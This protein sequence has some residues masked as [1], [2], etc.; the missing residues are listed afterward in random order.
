MC[1]KFRY[2]YIENC[3]NISSQT[4]LFTGAYA[5]LDEIKERLADLMPTH[6]SLTIEYY[7]KKFGM[8]NRRQIDELPSDLEDVYI[9]LRSKK[10]M[11]CHVCD[12]RNGNHDNK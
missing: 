4:P 11:T 1:D 5:T 6:P 7:N 3:S 10:P 12:G 2:I 9:Y 8:V